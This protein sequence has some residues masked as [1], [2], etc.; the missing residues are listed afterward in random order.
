MEPPPPGAQSWQYYY[1]AKKKG[2][3]EWKGH[4]CDYKDKNPE[5]YDAAVVYAKDL[6]S[7]FAK[8]IGI[9][10]MQ[11]VDEESMSKGAKLGAFKRPGMLKR[12]WRKTRTFFG[13]G[14]I[15]V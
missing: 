5:G 13:K 14:A 9:K 7:R 15:R 8:G 11:E 6:L 1:D 12:F 3:G 10:T 2:G 4:W